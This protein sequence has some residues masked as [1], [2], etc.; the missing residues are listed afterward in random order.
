[1]T[2]RFSDSRTWFRKSFNLKQQSNELKQS[3]AAENANLRPFRRDEVRGGGRGERAPPADSA[4]A[5]QETPLG[6]SFRM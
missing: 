2:L 3:P 1:M 4:D 5:G 6:A